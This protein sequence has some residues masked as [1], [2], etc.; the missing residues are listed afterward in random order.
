[1][2]VTEFVA[3]TISQIVNGVVQA[4]GTVKTVG[5]LVMPQGIICHHEDRGPQIAVADRIYVPITI[6]RFDVAVVASQAA[7][8]SGKVGLRVLEIGLGGQLSKAS[9]SESTS[10]IQFEIPVLLP[11]QPSPYR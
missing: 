7:E 6:V 11:S 10:R 3:E 5:A 8:Q 4:Q 2:N 9:T 1:M